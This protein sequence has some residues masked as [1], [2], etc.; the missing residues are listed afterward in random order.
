MFSEF[1]TISPHATLP[2]PPPNPHRV[3]SA[4]PAP[5]DLA[6]AAAD[7]GICNPAAPYPN[8]DAAVGL[9]RRLVSPD[10]PRISGADARN[11]YHPDEARNPQAGGGSALGDRVGGH[12]RDHLAAR[13]R[14]PH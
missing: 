13:R 10:D 2:H 11:P 5:A 8:P 4:F 14:H 7:L 9:D 3:L 12:R 6:S 1:V